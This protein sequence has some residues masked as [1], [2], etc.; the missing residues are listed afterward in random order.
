MFIWKLL[1]LCLL[2]VLD[3]CNSLVDFEILIKCEIISFN[4]LINSY[5]EKFFR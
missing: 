5:R 2:W 1:K 3:E 4:M